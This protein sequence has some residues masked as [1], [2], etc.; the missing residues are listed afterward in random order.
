MLIDVLTDNRN[1][2]LAEI[3]HALS[4]TGGRLGEPGCVAWIFKKKGV[5]RYHKKQEL[6]ED[7]LMEAAL[8]AGAEDLRDEGDYWEVLTDPAAFEAV[9]DKL[10]AAKLGNELINLVGN[11]GESICHSIAGFRHNAAIIDMKK[12]TA[13]GLN[14]AI[15]CDS[16]ARVDAENNHNWLILCISSSEI[17]MLE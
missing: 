1:R 3:R 11:E 5:L 7:Q 9:Q 17:F 6:S 4:K 2:S 8:G 12:V 15:T 13:I 14:E 16:G 10:Q